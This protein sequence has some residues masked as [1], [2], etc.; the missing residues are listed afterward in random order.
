ME[1]GNNKKEQMQLLYLQS[2]TNF[3]N[4]QYV[5]VVENK[6]SPEKK[7][8]EDSSLKNDHE[9][10]YKEHSAFQYYHPA[11]GADTEQDHTSLVERAFRLPAVHSLC[12]PL[13]L[14]LLPFETPVWALLVMGFLLGLTVDTFMNTAGSMPAPLC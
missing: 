11:A 6:M 4:L 1:N 10:L 7:V 2:S 12:Y 13:F 3:R 5:Y 8:L 9:R 14:L